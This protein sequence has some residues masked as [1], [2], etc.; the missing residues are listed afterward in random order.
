MIEDSIPGFRLGNIGDV[1]SGLKTESLF[2]S[3]IAI[4][5]VR[6]R[7]TRKNCEIERKERLYVFAGFV[8]A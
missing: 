7:V 6:R 1:K 8:I 4:P 2:G 3:S 5:F